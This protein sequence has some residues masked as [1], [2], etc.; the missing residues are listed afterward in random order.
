MSYFPTNPL[1]FIAA[2]WADQNGVE[3]VYN[4]VKERWARYAS[5]APAGTGTGDVTGPASSTVD[6]L[7]VFADASGNVIKD[8]GAPL[9]IGTSGTTAC[10]GNDARLS[11]DRDPT[12]HAHVIADI[13]DIGDASVS[14]AQ[15]SYL[16]DFG[17]TVEQVA[18]GL[19]IGDVAEF[20][21][22]A[23]A[24]AAFRQAL[25]TGAPGPTNFLRGDGSW[26]VLTSGFSGTAN[27]ITV[28]GTAD[29]NLESTI[30]TSGTNAT[31]NVVSLAVP[32]AVGSA[33]VNLLLTPKGTGAII[34]GPMPD[35]MATGGNARGAQAVDLQMSRSANTRVASG[36]GATIGGGNS[37]TAS[38]SETVL[39]GGTNNTASGQTSVISGGRLNTAS[40]LYSAVIGGDQNT[41]SGDASLAHGRTNTASGSGSIAM[42]REA[43][44]DREFMRAYANGKEGNNGDN[45]QVDFMLRKKTTDATPTAM[46]VYVGN[47]FIPVGKI[48]SGTLNV[49]GVK[50]DGSAVAHYLRQISVRNIV[51]TVA[52]VDTTADTVTFAT[53]HNL[54]DDQPIRITSTSTM[55][56]GMTE[57][58]VYYAKVIDATAISV[59]TATPVGA[60]N[61]VNLTSAGAGTRYLNYSALNYA[62]V[63]IGTDNAAGTSIAVTVTPAASV[64]DPTAGALTADY[65]AVTVTGIAAETWRW[66]GHIE[67]V[68]TAYG[69]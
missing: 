2:T 9:A 25:G 47:L 32:S 60:G 50:S 69:T 36:A 27:R 43:V 58:A 15:R 1:D 7:A 41:A 8:G 10:A 12:A 18:M 28:G 24:A 11:D 54:T 30:S 68:E 35:G 61:L 55:I 33:N 49:H 16:L 20:V 39:A 4:E 66:T 29:S 56:A 13:T 3:W 23:N 17:A 52:S 44:A 34:A 51:R 45:Q 48:I 31:V 46:G 38:G 22:G 26:Q 6:H 53:A 64:V 14:E 63:A 65:L 62:P 59:H 57:G 21:F 40:G 5:A 42:G 67:A 37:N 19:G